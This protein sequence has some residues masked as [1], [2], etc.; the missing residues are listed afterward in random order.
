MAVY[1]ILRVLADG[2]F[3]SGEEL[4]EVMGV[5]RTA[6]WKHLQKV[7]DLGL[8]LE[9]VKGKG[10]RVVGGVDL[11]DES[12][13]TKSL[14]GTASSLLSEL[15]VFPTINSTN[16]YLMNER[17]G[18]GEVCLAEQQSQ[19]RGRRGRVWVSPFAKNIYLSLSWTFTGGA[20]ALEGLSLAVGVAAV[21]ALDELGI[22]G[23]SLKWPNDLL[24]KG[25]K[26]GGILLEMTG[27]VSGDCRVVVGVGLNV[28][29]NN[30]NAAGIDQ[31][32]TSVNHIAGNV[33]GRNQISVAL[34]KR[35]LPLLNGY[36]NHGFGFYKNEWEALDAF[37]GQPVK[38]ISALTEK[39]GIAAGVTPTGA[40]RLDVDGCIEE[41]SGGEVSLRADV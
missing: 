34:I 33:V 27:D 7:G 25:R 26:L 10:Y 38:L 15:L 24:Y 3:H 23:V 29:M 4:G 11:L 2:A 28:D 9:S 41:F 22:K 8:Q 35:L 19:G 30:E 18:A 12:E 17:H 37:R 32:W 6:V 5:S 21:A 14:G 31:A 1:K 20:Q 16:H 39:R 36:T 40:L 13:I